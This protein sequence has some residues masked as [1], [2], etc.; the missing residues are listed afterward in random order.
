MLAWRIGISLVLVPLLL[1]LFYL[2]SR[3]GSSAPVLAVLCIFLATRSVWEL[4]KLFQ[5]RGLRPRKSFL[6]T[7]T[8]LLILAAWWPH[9]SGGSTDQAMAEF[10]PLGLTYSL[11][12]CAELFRQ[13][14]KFRE[15]GGTTENLGADLFIFSYAGMLLGATAQLRWVAGEQAGYLVLGSLLIAVKGGDIGGYTIGRIFGRRK[16]APVLSPGKTWAGGI[17][18]CATATIATWAWLTWVPPLFNS[19]FGPVPAVL[20]LTYGLAMGVVG[21]VG[22][23]CESLIKR[24]VGKKDAGSLFPGFGGILDLLDSIVYAGPVAYLFWKFTPLAAT[25]TAAAS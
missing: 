13:A 12:V 10:G 4:H 25:F 6:L 14:M 21:L 1:A 20:S 5:V 3:M 23:L 8:V 17:G 7:G 15:P 19:G 2:D 11:L 18:A 9:W 24:D 22:D 16:L